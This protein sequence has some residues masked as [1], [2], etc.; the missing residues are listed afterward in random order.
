MRNCGQYLDS[1]ARNVARIRTPVSLRN[2]H[3]K[4]AEQPHSDAAGN[5]PRSESHKPSSAG[6]PK[7]PASD[8]LR[9]DSEPTA[10]LFLDQKAYGTTPAT[11]QL[12]QGPHKLLLVA[13]GYQ[14]WRKEIRSSEPLSI[15]LARSELPEEVRGP[16]VVNVE[17][18]TEHSLRIL[19]DGIDTGQTCPTEDLRLS[20][21]S[22][23]FGF[24]NPVTGEQNEKQQKVKKSKSAVKLKVQF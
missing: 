6:K 23:T 11:L 9:V 19:V 13:D 4:E 5:A 10:K 21:G 1:S 20:V 12:S 7:A 3:P 17:C 2:A 18:K 15:R 14:L 22:H 16:A 24:L 8:E